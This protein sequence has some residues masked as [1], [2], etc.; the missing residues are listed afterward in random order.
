MFLKKVLSMLPFVGTLVALPLVWVHA[1]IYSPGQTLNPDCAPTDLNCGVEAP[2]SLTLTNVPAGSLIYTDATSTWSS[3]PIG[4]EGKVL[5]VVNGNLTWSNDAGGTI[6]SASEQGLHLDPSSNI[7]SLVLDGSSL[8]QSANGLKLSGSYGGQNTITTVGTIASG[9][10]QGAVVG[11]N[12]GGTGLSSTPSNGQV[13]IG[14]GSGYT[15]G[16][17]T[18]SNGVGVTAGAGSLA[19]NLDFNSL[20]T[21]SSLA[22]GD[23]FLVNASGTNKKIT[24]NDL[25]N[26]WGGA[27]KYQGSWNAASNNPLLTDSACTTLTEGGYYVVSASSTTTTLGGISTWNLNDW[28][29][30]NGSVWQKIQTTNAVSSVFGRTGTISAQS[31][32]YAA[33]QISFNATSTLSAN[34]VQSA[35]EQL[36]TNTQAFIPVGTISQYYRGDKTWQTLDTS[37]VAENPLNLYYTNTRARNALSVNG[38]GLTYSTSTG[39]IAI[40]SGYAVPL[41]AS[42]TIWDT[43]S[44]IVTA[45]STKWDMA[46]SWGNH[47]LAGYISSTTPT[48]TLTSGGLILASSSPTTT[49]G[50]LYNLAGNLYWNGNQ[51][52]IAN[53]NSGTMA[54][55]MLAWDGGKW[56]STTNISFATSTGLLSI[57]GTASST[58]LLVN[59]NATTTGNLA[60]NGN[61]TLATTT[62]TV[63]TIS[64]NGLILSSSTPSLTTNALYNLGGA[65]YW[66]GSRVGAGQ[67]IGTIGTL[68]LTDGLGN[69]VGSSLLSFATSTGIFSI[70]GIASTTALQINSATATSSALA[71]IANSL[72]TGSGISLTSSYASGNSTNGL[73]YVAN[74]GAVTNGIISRIQSNSTTGSGL[75]VWANGGVGI[76]TSAPTTN[77]LSVMGNVDLGNI[78]GKVN[79]NGAFLAYGGSGLNSYG[80]DLGYNSATSRY[81]TRL[82]TPTSADIVF[83]NIPTSTLP[84]S[85]ASTTPMMTIRGDTGYVGIGTSAPYEALHIAGDALL[86]GNSTRL[87]LAKNDGSDPAASTIWAMDNDAGT[88]YFRLFTQPTYS[89]GGVTRFAI[90]TSTGYLNI[91]MGAVGSSGVCYGIGFL[92]VIGT[93]SSDARLKTN[94]QD[95]AATSGLSAIMRL[96]P[97]SFDWRDATSSLQGTQM[98]FIAQELDPVLPGVISIGGT[99]TITLA[100]GSTQTITN[101]RSINYNALW[102]PTILAIQQLAVQNASTTLALTGTTTPGLAYVSTTTAEQTFESSWFAGILRSFLASVTNGIDTVIARVFKAQ[103]VDTQQLC[104]TDSSGA[105]TCITKDQLDALLSGKAQAASAGGGGSGGGGSS[106]ALGTVTLSINGNNPATI[107][108]GDSYKDLGATITS[109]ASARNLGIKASIDGGAPIDMS[110]VTIDT[111]VAGDHTIGYVVVDQTGATTT[112][113]RIVHVVAQSGSNQTATTTS[114]GTDTQPA[115]STP[116]DASSTPN[117]STSDFGAASSTA[118]N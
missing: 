78:P 58:A 20:G 96:R 62:A 9:T 52:G 19:L 49:T 113:E 33:N 90:N 42:S 81:S 37:A 107:L 22:N 13:M 16:S 4:G 80:M 40:G 30:C 6:Y 23:Y 10:W 79:F 14:N 61:I 67:A 91:T 103:E 60:V 57:N 71:I 77:A 106:S 35:L 55:Q 76:N 27:M 48:L 41:T 43:A 115:D 117:Q 93:C 54:G 65:L 56:S 25:A 109:P 68:Q 1:S 102:A 74:T 118:S 24:F 89:S 29:V 69:F 45:S 34:N 28:A 110:A 73:L 101:T 53:V 32:D 86:S 100:D 72:T 92:S 64:N 97:V 85:Q 11:V 94:I 70:S 63:L 104:V 83:A 15:L 38:T 5:K 88:G 21:V 26:I 111:S 12:Y 50:T 98:G 47:A 3:L 112:A 17:I 46:Y 18:G 66:S 95:L 87:I 105:K 8:A 84:P 116:Q 2:A 31:G 114:P 7:F 59:G 99:T 44:N 51:L 39:I 82:F 75:T 108:V 36:L